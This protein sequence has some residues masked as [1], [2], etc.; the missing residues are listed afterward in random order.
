VRSV[1]WGVNRPVPPTKVY[2][3]TSSTL[4]PERSYHLP[5]RKRRKYCCNSQALNIC[6]YS[7]RKCFL[8]STT[9]NAK[10][11]FLR[12]LIII[13][14]RIFYELKVPGAF[15]SPDIKKNFYLHGAHY[16]TRMVYLYM[17]FCKDSCKSFVYIDLQP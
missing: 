7:D 2:F 16:N 8:T 12:C 1:N 6:I 15:T 13:E 3:K 4:N 17:A 10:D 14:R 9:N 5:D 11:C